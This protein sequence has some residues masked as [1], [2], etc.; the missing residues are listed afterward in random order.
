MFCLSPTSQ[1]TLWSTCSRLDNCLL[2]SFSDSLLVFSALFDHIK[3]TSHHLPPPPPDQLFKC[4]VFL[5]ISHQCSRRP[6]C[7]YVV[8]SLSLLSLSSPPEFPLFEERD[9]CSEVFLVSAAPPPGEDKARN[10]RQLGLN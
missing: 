8:F 5:P 1:S 7:L 4:C 6:A 10:R 3:L 9:N 2:V